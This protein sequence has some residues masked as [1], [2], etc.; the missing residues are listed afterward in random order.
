MQAFGEWVLRRGLKQVLKRNLAN[1]LAT[2]IDTEQ[3]GVQLEKGSLEL[4]DC[5]LDTD[6]LNERWVSCPSGP[7][8]CNLFKA[9]YIHSIRSLNDN[10]INFIVLAGPGN[11][12]TV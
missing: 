12:H 6:Y 3:L 8:V 7:K 5:L 4:K 2:E 10:K 1:L 11:R 9:H